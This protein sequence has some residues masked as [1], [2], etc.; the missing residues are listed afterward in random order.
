MGSPMIQVDELWLAPGE[1]F[2]EFVILHSAAQGVG[3]C[4]VEKGQKYGFQVTDREYL[5]KSGKYAWK[6]H[7]GPGEPMEAKK[8]YYLNAPDINT[9]E[10]S[11][12]PPPVQNVRKRGKKR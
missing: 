12:S 2:I 10:P 9:N 3:L 4:R 6:G 8:L 1:Y 5:P 7:C 11:P